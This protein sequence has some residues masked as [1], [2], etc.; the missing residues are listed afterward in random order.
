M[1]VIFFFQSQNRRQT[2]PLTCTCQAQVNFSSRTQ[3]IHYGRDFFLNHWWRRKGT[4]SFNIFLS[5]CT[6]DLIVQF[7]RIILKV[8]LILSW[9]ER[10]LVIYFF[11]EQQPPP[12]PPPRKS[13]ASASGVSRVTLTR[14]LIVDALWKRYNLHCTD[15]WTGNLSRKRQRAEDMKKL[16]ASIWSEIDNIVNVSR[17]DYWWWWWCGPYESM[18]QCQ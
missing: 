13:V 9:Q 18:Y 14:D 15:L 1:W 16:L 4:S 10:Y 17:K 6:V 7:Y 2:F 11:H 5:K 3:V 12:P 8:I